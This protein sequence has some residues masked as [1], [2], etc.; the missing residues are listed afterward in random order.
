MLCLSCSNNKDVPLDHDSGAATALG[1]IETQATDT[2][3]VGTINGDS[4]ALIAAAHERC[5]LDPTL[6]FEE[7]LKKIIKPPSLISVDGGASFASTITTNTLT[8]K[9]N[10]PSNRASS[11]RTHSPFP[12]VSIELT[13]LRA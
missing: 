9:N 3:S 8:P 10:N 7:E 12:A 13:L 6:I 4:I 2:H 5:R 11:P 1:V